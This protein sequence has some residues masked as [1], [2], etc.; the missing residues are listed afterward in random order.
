MYVHFAKVSV[1]ALRQ[2]KLRRRSKSYELKEPSIRRDRASAFFHYLRDDSPDVF[3]VSFDFEKNQPLPKVLDS[4]AYYSRQFYLYNFTPVVGH[5]K[6]RLTKN[7]VT[8][9][10]WTEDTFKKDGNTIALC[11]FHLLRE[12]D[13]TNYKTVRLMCD[14][15]GGQNK[16]SVIVTMCIHWLAQFA[17]SHIKELVLI[18][19]VTGHSF[20]PPDRVFRNIEKLI[21]TFDT[22]VTPAELLSYIGHFAKVGSFVT[23]KQLV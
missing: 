16:D 13:L 8:A 2:V 23:S 17:P 15:C 14:G 4:A 1:S 12:T 20:L 6:S 18:F 11:L 19:P 3:L 5:S 9:F 22:I 21:K 7:N 10:C